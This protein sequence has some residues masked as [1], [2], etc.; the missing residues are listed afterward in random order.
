MA[1]DDE[2]ELI[3]WLL[4]GDAC[5]RYLTQRQVLGLNGEELRPFEKDLLSDARIKELAREVAQWPWPPLISHK[6]AGHPIHKLAFLS[7]LEIHPKVLGLE[8]LIG[9]ILKASSEEGQLQVPTKISKSYG[10][11]GEL[12]YSWALC[13]APLMIYSLSKLGYQN[14]TAVKKGAEHLMSLSRNNGFPCAVSANLGK[15]RGPG[16]KEDPCPYATLIMLKL[17]AQI[18]VMRDG[19]VARKSSN[20]L[21]ELWTQSRERHPYMFFM[22]TDFRK[23]KAPLVWYDI[24]HVADVLSRFP[25]MRKDERFLEM[26]ELI[27]SKADDKGRYT[28]ES[29]WEAWKEWDF[30]QKKQPSRGLTLLIARLMSRV[31]S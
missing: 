1:S 5:V 7:D 3:E 21:L 15:F 13:D 18:P 14:H 16:R 22:G 17:L 29:A 4:E 12:E 11:N 9:N 6:S 26:V 30:G 8:G 24:L 10:G 27:R 23:L 31:Y 2:P 19:A 28:P 25:W 20:S